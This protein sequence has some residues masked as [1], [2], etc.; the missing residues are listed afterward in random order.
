MAQSRRGYHLRVLARLRGFEIT[1]AVVSTLT[2]QGGLFTI[3]ATWES[4]PGESR[5][6][7]AIHA[8]V[9]V[10]RAGAHA[11]PVRPVTPALAVAAPR[12]A[13]NTSLAGIRTGGEIRLPGRVPRHVPSTRDG[14]RRNQCR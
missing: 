9:G 2:N 8:V 3:A 11:S 7:A 6:A 12:G 5:Q 1:A 14:G 10:P 13:D 4:A